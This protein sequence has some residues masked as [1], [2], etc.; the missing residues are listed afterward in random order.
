MNDGRPHPS[1][2]D[3]LDRFIAA[4]H[5][6]EAPSVDAYLSLTA[7]A[8]RDELL[9][10]LG[11]FLQMAPTVEPTTTRGLELIEDPLVHRLARLEDEWWDAQAPWGTRLQA[12]R[13]QAG[14]SLQQLG[15]RFASHFSLSAADA[16]GVP[17]ALERLEA[18]SAPASGVTARAARALEELLGAAR[19]SLAA[20]AAP[21]LGAALMR[22]DGEREQLAD[23]L[24]HVDDALPA[25]DGEETGETLHGLLGLEP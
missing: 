3:L 7:E 5:A 11:A 12:L 21:P 15:E 6:G 2:D 9:E 16:S 19:G 23:L 10:L 24:R 17:D 13:V 22:S 18:A 20:G 8:D 4:W 14:L 1:V 25:G